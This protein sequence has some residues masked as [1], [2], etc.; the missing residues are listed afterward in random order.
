MIR[1]FVMD[2][3]GTLTDGK[4]YIGPQGEVMKAFSVKDGLGITKLSSMGIIPVIITGRNSEIVTNRAKELN[5]PEVYQGIYDKASKLKSII[6]KYDCSYDEI[7]YIGDDENDLECME[8]CGMKGCP[9]DAEEKVKMKAN[10][11]CSKVGGD[12][13]VREF[14]EHIIK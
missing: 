5:I 11:V 7:A 8:L 13:A 2:I 3:D 4:I 10:F 1:L 6:Q 12:G 9:A 14:I